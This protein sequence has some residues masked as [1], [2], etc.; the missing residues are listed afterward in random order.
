MHNTRTCATTTSIQISGVDLV[1]VAARCAL[2]HLLALGA[3]PA[4]R[5]ACAQE[6]QDR[7]DSEAAAAATHALRRTD[8][9]AARAARARGRHV[10][11]RRQERAV[12]VSGVRVAGRQALLPSIQHVGC[13]PRYQ[14]GSTTR[15]TGIT[16]PL[17]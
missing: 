12:P 15:R 4:A 6:H 5:A 10:V 9:G 16:H 13:L 14:H 7:P 8:L 11:G 1:H 2:L 3:G 17:A